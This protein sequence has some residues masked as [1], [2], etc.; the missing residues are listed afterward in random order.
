MLE[1]SKFIDNNHNIDLFYI[2]S[3]AQKYISPKKSGKKIN[4]TDFA[5]YLGNK[6]FANLSTPIGHVKVNVKSQFGKMQYAKE[7]RKNLLYL[8]K[9]T[10]K[11]PMLIFALNN[12]SIAFFNSFKRDGKNSKLFSVLSI[13]GYV[14]NELILK[15]S[16]QINKY[17]N[18]VNAIVEKERLLYDKSDPSIIK[19]TRNILQMFNSN[20]IVEPDK[21]LIEF[22]K[23]I[24]VSEKDIKKSISTDE[25]ANLVSIESSS[26]SKDVF[27]ED[28]NIDEQEN[29]NVVTL[30]Q[31]GIS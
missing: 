23:T 7:N 4:L 5:N 29:I 19:N 12:G 6:K 3:I 30:P 1:N 20:K 24:S 9:P 18:V 22:L 27:E 10:L 31:L 21:D 28:I 25:I 14:N 16:Y 15:T 8:I 11:K 2:K 13:C 17:S 26:N